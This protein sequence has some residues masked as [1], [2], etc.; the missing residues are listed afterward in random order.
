MR[1]VKAENATGGAN[2]NLAVR[3]EGKTVG[4]IQFVE[5]AGADVTVFTSAQPPERSPVFNPA[6]HVGDDE[7]TTGQHNKATG[8]PEPFGDQ[9]HTKSRRR[10]Q[11]HTG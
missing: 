11:G 7:V 5:Q 10:F 9:T 8:I 1:R 4:P 6:K 2:V 3:S